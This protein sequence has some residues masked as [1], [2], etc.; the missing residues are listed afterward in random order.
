MQF[1]WFYD[2]E[3]KISRD[4]YCLKPNNSAI[5]TSC[6]NQKNT[7]SYFARGWKTSKFSF[8]LYFL[9]FANCIKQDCKRQ[10]FR[11]CDIRGI[12]QRHFGVF[13]HFKDFCRKNIFFAFWGFSRNLIIFFV[14][15]NWS[16][17]HNLYWTLYVP[18]QLEYIFIDRVSMSNV[19]FAAKRD[20]K[21]WRVWGGFFLWYWINADIRKG[22]RVKHEFTHV[23]R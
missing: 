16:V 23:L 12:C 13:Q 11:E 3:T 19:K 18:N 17:K 8:R 21:S 1:K 5:P 2:K 15:L 14:F 10:Q 7:Q 9:Y 4:T 6:I 20:V 22:F